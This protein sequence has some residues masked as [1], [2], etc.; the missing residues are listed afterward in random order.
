MWKLGK[1]ALL[2]RHAAGVTSVRISPSDQRVFSSSLDGKVR[3]WGS[4]K[5][6]IHFPKV[7]LYPKSKMVPTSATTLA[8][9]DKY[10]VCGMH[11]GTVELYSPADGQLQGSGFARFDNRAVVPPYC[12][13]VVILGAG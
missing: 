8:I 5:A 6:F 2:G 7:R 12:H 4:R 11:N 10:L 9:N 1:P 3:V 13:Q